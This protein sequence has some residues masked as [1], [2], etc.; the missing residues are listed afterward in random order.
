MGVQHSLAAV[1]AGRDRLIGPLLILSLALLAAGLALPALSIGN[2]LVRKDYSILQGVWAFYKAGDYFL[3][4]VVGVFS[5]VLP[6]IKTLLSSYVW[7]AVPRGGRRA[8]RI[9]RILAGISKWSM[10]D[11]FIIA[12]TML[13]IE[14]SLL[15]SADVHAGI[16]TFAAAV[17]LS[18]VAIR[19]MAQL[20][21]QP[22]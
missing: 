4:I 7:F 19:R 2:F 9:V 14:G 3:F 5:V 15:T 6:T 8:E 16:F 18:T 22:Q 20:M 17:L 10:L 21:A 13:V 1:A 12:V 11:V